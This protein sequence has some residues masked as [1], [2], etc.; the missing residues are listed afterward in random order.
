MRILAFC[1]LLLCARAYQAQASDIVISYVVEVPTQQIGGQRGTAKELLS[2]SLP[3]PG[4]WTYQEN[5]HTFGYVY[6]D[7]TAPDFKRASEW[8]INIGG[9]IYKADD[10]IT[11]ESG[12][13]AIEIP[14][15]DA[16]TAAI[17]QRS[18]WRAPLVNQIDLAW[19]PLEG[20]RVK[21]TIT[22]NSARTLALGGGEPGDAQTPTL[23]SQ[24]H[25]VATRDGQSVGPARRVLP[26]GKPGTTTDLQAGKSR[27]SVFD[28]NDY[29]DFSRPGHYKITASY[30]LLWKSDAPNQAEPVELPF[31][32]AFELDVP[33]KP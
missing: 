26:V 29:G 8:Q 33:A 3:V 6:V 30:K 1:F 28:L 5:G 7:P 14:D 13:T 10:T 16:Q 31:E 17:L 11:W 19:Q 25:I 20:T 9:H 18:G 2:Y 21:L 23:D 32:E 24:M 4:A 15:I 12:E 22:N 27:E